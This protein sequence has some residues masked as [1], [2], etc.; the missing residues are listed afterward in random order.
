MNYLD[1]ECDQ[2]DIKG[3]F[4]NGDIDKEIFICPP[5]GS[6]VPATSVLKLK[7]SLY[8]LKQSPRLFNQALDKWLQSQGLRP[9]TA[10]PCLYVQRSGK[11]VLL[12]SVHVDDQ[13]IA[14]NN[15]AELDEFKTKLNNKFECSDGG[16]A[17]YFLGISITRNRAKRQL[18]LAQTHYLETLLEQYGMTTANPARTPLPSRRPIKLS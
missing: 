17:G 8:G 9:T 1:Y 2:V 7:K 3:A 11:S 6:N 16:P 12:L 14:C 13:L 5:E 4:L 18:H 10:D 15:R